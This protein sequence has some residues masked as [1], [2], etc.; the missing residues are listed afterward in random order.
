MRGTEKKKTLDI[1]GV[2]KL[3]RTESYCGEDVEAGKSKQLLKGTR[4]QGLSTVE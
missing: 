2:K 3:R 1:I 4:E